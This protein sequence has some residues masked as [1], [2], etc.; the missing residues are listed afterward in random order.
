[1]PVPSSSSPNEYL[2]SLCQKGLSKRYQN[3]DESILKRMDFELRVIDEMGFNDYFLIVWDLVRFA[4]KNGIAVG[5]GRGSAAGSLVA[6]LLGITQVDPIR[7]DLLFERFLNP[8]RINMPDIDIDFDY[9]RRDEVIEYAR[10]RF[11]EDRV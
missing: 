9:E 11:G 3:P 7:Y 2:A 5:P 6:Y 1:F 4:W 10:K 8:E